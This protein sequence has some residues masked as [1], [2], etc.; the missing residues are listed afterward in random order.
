MSKCER[1]Q[2]RSAYHDGELS[3]SAAAEFEEHL[4]QCGDCAAELGELRELSKLIGGVVEPEM[5]SRVLRRLHRR[6]DDASQAGVLRVVQVMSAA[7]AAILIV[8]SAWMWRLSASAVEPD[9]SPQWEQVALRQD[10]VSAAETSE[11]QLAMWM[12]ERLTG[13]ADDRD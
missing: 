9:Q 7:A 11:E 4:R 10:E 2:Q 3:E 12:I 1:E 5:P 8:C 13:N 6:A